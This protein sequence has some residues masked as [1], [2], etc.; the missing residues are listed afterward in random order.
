MALPTLEFGSISITPI[1]DSAIRVPGDVLYR[2]GAEHFPVLDGTRGLVSEDWAEHPEHLDPEGLFHMHF[3]GYLIRGVGDRVIL[4][5]L[6]VG[7]DPFA[8]PGMPRPYNGVLLESLR[9]EGIEASDVTDVVLTHLHMDHIGWA[10]IAGDPVFTSATYRCAVQDWTALSRINPPTQALL[11]PVEGRLETWDADSTIFPGVDAR[12]MPGHTPGSTAIVVSS[13]ASRAFLVGDIA[14]CP[15]EFMYRDW[16]GLG[17]VDPQQASDARQDL[18]D[19]LVRTG[20]WAGSTHFAG[21]GIG[22]L[23]GEPGARSFRADVERVDDLERAG[24]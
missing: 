11:D 21:L 19:E 15:H 12:V 4:V 10:S 3:G 22:R 2:A 17:D 18:A 14:H 16:A 9:A 8:P 6:G 5:D 1:L 7:P 20:A 23:S 24:R 13:G